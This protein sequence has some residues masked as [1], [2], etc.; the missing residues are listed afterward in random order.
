M[1]SYETASR[2]FPRIKTHGLRLRVSGNL[3]KE[4][5]SYS[6]ASNS[7]SRRRTANLR[8]ESKH[9]GRWRLVPRHE[10]GAIL[11]TESQ[12]H[13]PA[14]RS[15][16]DSAWRRRGL[17]IAKR[18]ALMAPKDGTSRLPVGGPL[19]LADARYLQHE[20]AKLGVTAKIRSDRSSGSR[21]SLHLVLVSP[22][23]LKQAELAR[24]QLL[25]DPDPSDEVDSDSETKHRASRKS[26][27]VLG[28]LGFVTGLR[29]GARAFG[30]V[31][32]GIALAAVL[33]VAAFGATRLFF[34]SPGE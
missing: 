7:N 24:E 18:T 17:V 14:D 9:R 12:C 6:V 11:P 5:K 20:L 2:A 26:A 29:V 28:L 19:D 31:W 22:G 10:A 25:S 1:A 21:Q 33:S 27:L 13:I 16:D 15:L 8:V 3:K 32:L 4:S 34:Q 23:A 30:S